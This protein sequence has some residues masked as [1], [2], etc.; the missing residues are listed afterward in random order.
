MWAFICTP[1]LG[2]TSG[3]EWEWQGN[4]HSSLADLLVWWASSFYNITWVCATWWAASW[5]HLSPSVILTQRIL[6][7]YIFSYSKSVFERGTFIRCVF[8]TLVISQTCANSRNWVRNIK[9][10]NLVGLSC[11]S[12]LLFW[13]RGFVLFLATQHLSCTTAFPPKPAFP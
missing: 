3:R 7:V 6:N 12:H 1:D 8:S 9:W 4:L 11:P 5:S 10:I 2:P 13:T